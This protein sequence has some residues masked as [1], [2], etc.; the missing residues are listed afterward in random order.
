MRYRFLY[1]SLPDRSVFDQHV[2]EILASGWLSNA[3]PKVQVLEEALAAELG[4]DHV[5]CVSSGSLGLLILLRALGIPRGTEVLLPAFNFPAPAEA[6]LWNGLRLRYAEVRSDL[7]T[8]DPEDAS[9]RCSAQTR[10]LMPVHALGNLADVDAFVAL[11]EE[12]DLLLIFD[13]ASATGS[14]L[15]CRRVARAGEGTVVSLH[16]TKVLPAGEGGIIMTDDGALADECRRLINF[17]FEVDRGVRRYGI[18]AKMSELNAAFALAGLETL[19]TNLQLRRE[20][21]EAYLESLVRVPW[22]VPHVDRAA[23]MQLFPVT[24]APAYPASGRLALRQRWETDGIETRCYYD[25][26]LHRMAAFQPPDPVSLP[27]TEDLCAR[28]I[29][30]P[31]HT[32]LTPESVA[33]IVSRIEA[34]GA[35]VC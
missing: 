21:A 28:V 12:R 32:R 27:I 7:L 6:A 5:V 17:G 10:L 4:V 30:L 26:P 11:A 35:P 22:L 9:Q 25:P 16:A 29:C 23:V 1:P 33:D 3:G 8:L 14:L 24:L 31:F 15:L 19:E 13:G 2:D 20:L 34:A 18:N